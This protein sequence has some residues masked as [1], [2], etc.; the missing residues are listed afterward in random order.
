[1]ASW[2]YARQQQAIVYSN[3]QGEP[4]YNHGQHQH[5]QQYAPAAAYSNH[6]GGAQYNHGQQRYQQQQQHHH[7]QQQQH[8]HHHHQ[9]P[10]GGGA[11]QADRQKH[12]ALNQRITS[13][14]SA[15]EIL[16]IYEHDGRD[17]NEVN[18]AKAM[19]RLG[20][21]GAASQ[22]PD[23]PRLRALIDQMTLSV[24]THGWDPRHLAHACWAVAKLKVA[25][26]TLFKAVAAE[27]RSQMWHFNPQN[28]ANTAWAFATAG[29]SSPRLF[30]AIAA[31]APAQMRRFKPQELT[32]TAWAFAT[33]G[34]SSPRLF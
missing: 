17:F 28:L 22:R 6:Q 7:Q 33:A 34:I 18:L 13:S 8:H 1:M 11:P 10:R 16:S 26:P 3:H 2:Q 9:H 23:D 4:R 14:T 31:E 24:G 15:A 30:E 32:N 19:H 20:K 12:I 27:A 25:A 21:S 5:Q 29:I